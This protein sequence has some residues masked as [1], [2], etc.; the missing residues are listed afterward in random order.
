LQKSWW[1]YSDEPNTLAKAERSPSWRKGMV[2]EMESIEDNQTWSLVDLP[3][4][5]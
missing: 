2:E 5:D 3:V 1:W 4:R